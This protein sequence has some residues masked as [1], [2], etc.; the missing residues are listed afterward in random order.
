M[1]SEQGVHPQDVSEGLTDYHSHQQSD[2]S[3][4]DALTMWLK[5]VGRRNLLT[6]EQEV[7][8]A[9][10]A[11]RGCVQSKK[12]LVE[13]NLRLVVSIAKRFAGRGLPLGDLIQEGN[14][15]LVRAVEKFDP[16]RGYRFSTYATWWIRQ[17]V[18]RAIS[19]QAR[20]IR[21]PVHMNETLGRVARTASSLEQ[22]LGREPT[23]HEIAQ[24]ANLSPTRVQMLLGVPSDATS[25]EIQIG[26]EGDFRL[27][28]LVMDQSSGEEVEK[29]L[30]SLDIKSSLQ[31]ITN[32]S[33]RERCVL[34]LRYGLGNRAPMAV[35]EIATELGVSKERVR[36]LE[37][38][39]MR[40]LRTPESRKLMSRVLLD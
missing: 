14:L 34:E 1:H 3:S 20:T 13:A 39:S 11:E 22:S 38:R 33:D 36:Q 21:L 7:E 12:E 40:K 26:P 23:V 32:L 28:E 29:S 9:K 6:K 24:H 37:A 16:E 18:S 10:R 17:A 2:A 15:G 31:F 27:A 4:L 25:L 19:D 5:L 8:L 35:E 30:Q